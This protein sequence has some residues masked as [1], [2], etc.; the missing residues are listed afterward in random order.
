ML[1]DCAFQYVVIPTRRSSALAIQIL[2]SHALGDAG[3]PYIVGL[4]SNSCFRPKNT[5]IL[6]YYLL[7]KK[8]NKVVAESHCNLVK[9]IILHHVSKKLSPLNF[10]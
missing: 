3:S 10:L 9:Y 4:V 6:L 2:M 7:Q 1:S 8:S 5:F